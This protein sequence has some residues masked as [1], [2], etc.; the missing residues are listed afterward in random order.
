[1][2]AILG[3]NCIDGV[4]LL[5]DTEE[6]VGADS[7]SECHKL[8]RLN[9][10]H[11][12]MLIGGSGDSH[13]VE[14]ATFRMSQRLLQRSRSW[15]EVE[16]DLNEFAKSITKETLGA[17][18][19][20]QDAELTYGISMLMAVNMDGRTAMFKWDHNVV[21]P[22]LP[23]SHTSIGGGITTTH[24]LLHDIQFSMSARAMLF[25][26]ARIMFEAKRTVSGV[27][28]KTEAMVLHHNGVGGLFSTGTMAVIE[29]FTAEVKDFSHEVLTTLITA[30]DA[31]KEFEK[32]L[33]LL[34]ARIRLLRERYRSI[35]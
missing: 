32:G 1:M 2:T 31:D 29:N 24:P 12:R 9:L 28:G 5:T 22:I 16:E 15:L 18:K 4:L 7:K 33:E 8:T 14:Y 34:A 23:Y 10:P 21:V 20:F 19:G 30:A 27:G 13:F 35:S 3:F 11:G 25:H 6:S 26:G 17:Y